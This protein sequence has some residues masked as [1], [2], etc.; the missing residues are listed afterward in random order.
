[1]WHYNPFKDVIKKKAPTKAVIK[2]KAKAHATARKKCVGD[3]ALKDK[4]GHSIA[5]GSGYDSK[6]SYFLISMFRRFRCLVCWALVL[7]FLRGCTSRV[8]TCIMVFCQIYTLVLCRYVGCQDT[9]WGQRKC[10]KW[11]D[12]KVLKWT[13]GA[14]EKTLD[15]YAKTHG[16]CRNSK[17]VGKTIWCWIDVENKKK[18]RGFSWDYCDPLG[19][20]KKRIQITA[21]A[22]FI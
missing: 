18:K 10:Q 13:K 7:F 8:S 2:K 5:Q 11:N 14:Y 9:T 15:A 12:P 3:E 19:P 22:F 16:V 6:R 21:M 20:G 1:M 17:A 4:H